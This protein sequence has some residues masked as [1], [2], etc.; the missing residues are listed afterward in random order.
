VELIGVAAAA[1]V[2]LNLASMN[3]LQA[4]LCAVDRLHKYMPLFSVLKVTLALNS[5]RFYI[6]MLGSVP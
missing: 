4:R 2:N 1:V 3:N 6:S 5:S